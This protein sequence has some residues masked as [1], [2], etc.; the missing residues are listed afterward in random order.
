MALFTKYDAPP[1]IASQYA[2]SFPF[3]DVGNKYVDIGAQYVPS[4]LAGLTW[5]QVATDMRNPSSAVAKDIDG[6][7]NSI[8]AAICKADPSAPKSVCDSPAAIAGAKD[9]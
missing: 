3:I 8:T 5:S 6:T 2:G 9:I 1:Y 7:A 4:A